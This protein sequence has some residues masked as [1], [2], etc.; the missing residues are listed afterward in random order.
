MRFAFVFGILM[1]VLAL[2]LPVAE[3]GDSNLVKARQVT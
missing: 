2:A 1:P 3:N